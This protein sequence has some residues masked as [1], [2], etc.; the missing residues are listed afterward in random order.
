[1]ILDAIKAFVCGVQG[2]EVGQWINE[3]TEG[4]SGFGGEN[5]ITRFSSPVS[6]AA[7]LVNRRTE[8]QPTFSWQAWRVF[9]Q[10][11]GLAGNVGITFLVEPRKRGRA[12]CRYL[13]Q[14]R[15]Y[16]SENPEPGARAA[17]S[18]IPGGPSEN[19]CPRPWFKAHR[20]ATQTL[21]RRVLARSRV[22]LL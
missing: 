1:M 12:V 15:C 2:A 18:T 3:I 9:I 20:H 4:V 14:R 17:A 22:V 10:D 8:Q 11:G 19:P 5:V 16:A 6:T 21:A 7:W 13:R